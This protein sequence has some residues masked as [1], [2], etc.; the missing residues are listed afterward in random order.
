[1]LVEE[2]FTGAKAC[3]KNVWRNCQDFFF[4]IAAKSYST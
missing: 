2:N 1:M 3:S 4:L